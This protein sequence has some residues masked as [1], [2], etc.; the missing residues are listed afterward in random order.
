M[1]KRNIS[2]TNEEKERKKAGNDYRGRKNKQIKEVRKRKFISKKNE[3][4]I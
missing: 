4:T 1:N 2:E 3:K